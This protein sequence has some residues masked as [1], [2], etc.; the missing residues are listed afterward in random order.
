MAVLETKFQDWA[1]RLKI[2]SDEIGKEMQRIND[3]HP[4]GGIEDVGWKV[5]EALEMIEVTCG[6]KPKKIKKSK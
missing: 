3:E 6:V 5:D 2:I 1:N 4:Y